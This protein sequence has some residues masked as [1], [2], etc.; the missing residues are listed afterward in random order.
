MTRAEDRL[1]IAGAGPKSGLAATPWY[2]YLADGF[3]RLTGGGE[4]GERQLWE[5]VQRKEVEPAEAPQGRAAA[6]LGDWVA[7]NAPAEPA[8]GRPLAPSRPAEG[9]PAPFSPTGETARLGLIRGRLIHRLLQSLPDLPPPQRA[10]AAERYLAKAA[11]DFSPAERKALAGEALAVLSLPEAAPYFGSGSLAE[12]PLTG[13]VGE[14]ALNGQIDRLAVSDDKVL[15]L[16]F[17]TNR[18]MPERLEDVPRAYLRQL[19]LYAALLGKVYPGRQVECAL[20]WTAAPR[21]MRIDSA[22]LEGLAS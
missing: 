20:L 22:L 3:A 1:Y 7:R 5:S 11:R 15:V 10:A 12:V 6:P 9:E 4:P 13:L 2:D 8:P 19:A 14:T 21:F 16:E 17:K 18:P